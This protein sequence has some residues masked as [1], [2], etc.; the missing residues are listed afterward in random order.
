MN[1]MHGMAAILLCGASVRAAPVNWAR[2]GTARASDSENA[3]FVPALAVDGVVNRDAPSARQSR[4]GSALRDRF[5]QGVW[6]GT[7]LWLDVDLGAVRGGLRDVVIEWEIAKAVDY[8]IQ[9]SEDGEHWRT[10]WRSSG[11]SPHVREHIRLPRAERARYVRLDVTRF[12]RDNWGT[13]S[14]YEFEV[15]EGMLPD[16]VETLA[17][18]MAPSNVDLSGGRIALALPPGVTAR[19]AGSTHR[20]VIAMDGRIR[21][22]LSDVAAEVT[23]ELSDGRDRAL[24][25]PLT[26]GV[27]GTAPPRPGA[28]PKPEVIPALQ[29]WAGAAGLFALKD[30]ARVLIREEDA[31]RGDPTLRQRMETFAADY[32][33]M[34]GRPLSVATAPAARPGEIFVALNG[35]PALGTEGYGIAAGDDLTI[36]AADPAGAFWA[37]RTL[38]QVMKAMDGKFPRGQAWDYPRYPVRGFMYDV[39][40]KPATL[41]A[42]YDVMRMMSWYKLNDLQLHLNDNFIWLHDYTAIPNGPDATPEQKR[43]AIAEVLAAAP[44]AF[45]LESSARGPDGTAL[46]AA[47]HFYTREE[48]RRLIDDARLH[49]VRIVPEIDVP[50]HAMSFVRVRPDLMYRGRVTKPH[51]VERAAML[52]VSNDLFD[53][54]TGRTYREETLSFV[55]GVFDEYLAGPDPVFRDGVVHIGTDE[56]YGDAEDYRAFADAMLKYVRARGFTPRLWGSLRAKPGR[57]PVTGEGAQMHI[58]SLSWQLPGPAIEAGFDIINILD[59]DTY[60]VPN[61]TGNVGGYGDVLNLENLYAPRWQPHVMQQYSVPPGHPQM[62]GAQWALWN[63]N[64]FRR[65]TGLQDYDLFDRIWKTSSVV[66]EKTW[67]A[68]TDRT[69]GEFMGGVRRLGL[70][71][72]ALYPDM[73]APDYTAEFRVRRATGAAEPQALF[74]ASTGALMA[75]QKDTGRVGLSRNA[76]DYSF[77]YTLPVGEWVTLKLVAKGRSL[78]L[79]ADGVEIGPPR[80]HRYPESH[81]FSTFIFPSPA[82]QETN[83]QGEIA[84]LRIERAGSP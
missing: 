37:T 28:N 6:E 4:W 64:S 49:G 39:G 73:I 82:I 38:L 25:A 16:T 57:T 13:I 36:R 29:E 18:R 7:G 14:I 26:I 20:P 19:V 43:A 33:A 75:V 84:D 22:P 74:T 27:P 79:F 40:R 47:D 78:T 59:V 58:W 41:E 32:A 61:G 65:D 53:P 34:T 55:Q 35:H 30:G 2:G 24:T 50:G 17:R 68:G 67:H 69:Y 66:A 15:Y 45:R 1:R 21:R 42:I 10:A 80:R 60:I 83:F 8:T 46:T 81:K 77:D 31:G 48:F 71:P 63:D 23:F 72:R 52:D 44:T 62:L 56:Y 54:A 5:T 12:N 51:D 9:L 3:T 76:W 70:P 11:V